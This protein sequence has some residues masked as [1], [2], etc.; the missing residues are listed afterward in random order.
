[1]SFSRLGGLDVDGDA[2]FND[3]VAV[4]VLAPTARLHLAA[5]TAVAGTASLKVGAGLLLAVT[6][7]GAVESD[8]AHLYW[9]DGG[10][11]RLQLDGGGGTLSDAYDAGAAAA[12]QTLVIL[13]ARGG[14]VVV[15]GTQAGFTGPVSLEVVNATGSVSFPRLGGLDVDGDAVFT[16]S[17]AV[18]VLAPTARLHLAAG[19][20]VAGTAS[21]KIDAGVLLAV[22]ESGAVE[23]DGT[24]LYWTDG[25]GTRLRL[26]GGGETLSQTYDA[27]AAAADQTLVILDARGGGVV[28]NATAVGL[29]AVTA[30]EVDVIGGSVNFYTAGG[31]DV[32]STISKVAAA[33]T[34]WNEVDLASSTLTLTGGPT[35]ATSVSMVRVGQ[36][37]INGA[38]TVTDAYNLRVDTSPAGTATLTR[39]WSLGAAGAVQFAAGL[40]LGAGLAAP[41]END[42][43]VGAG[44]T[45]VSEAN[46]GRLGYLA[47]ATQQFM[48]SL[49]TAAYVPL[50]VGPAVGGFTTGSVPFGVAGG[51]LSQDNPNFFWDN[52][53]K[54]L[55]VGVTPTA[56]LHVVQPL[57]NASVPTA[58][59]V[60]G[61]SHT[62]I[63]ASSECIGANFNFSA[64][65]Q[66]ATGALATQREIVFQ[67]PTYRFVGNSTITTA[68]TVAITG[69]PVAGTNATLTNPYALLVQSGQTRFNAGNLSSSNGDK[70]GLTITA[71][72]TTGT[73][74]GSNFA[75]LYLNYVLDQTS[76]AD[77][78]GIL[79]N[80]TQTS[81]LGSHSPIAVVIDTHPIFRMDGYGHLDIVETGQFGFTPVPIL[82]VEQLSGN[83]SIDAGVEWNMVRFDL[84]SNEQWSTGAL[85]TQRAFLINAPTYAFVGAS[86]LTTAA[87]MA[88]SGAPIKGANATLTNTSAL[89]LQGTY[90]LTTSS[91][92]INELA[93]V[94]T[95]NSSAG[96]AAFNAVNLGYTINQTGTSSG[97]VNGLRINAAETAVLGT[98]NLI[99]AQ[100]GA[101]D[102]FVVNRRGGVTITQGIVAGTT[103]FA[104]ALTVTGAAH[105]T[106][107]LSTEVVG[108]NL[109]LS[110]TKQWATGAIT[111][112]REVLVQ[113]PTYSFVGAST[114][115]TAATLAITDAPAAGA[116]ATLTTTLALWVQAGASRFVPTKN[117]VA[118]AGISWDGF[119]VAPA[120]LSIT[121]AT[122]PITSLNFV[123]I[124]QPTLSAASPVVTTDL[125][126]LRV[127]S[128]AFAGA[129]PASATRSWSLYVE[130]NARLGAGQTVAG[131]DVNAAGPYDV[132][133]TDYLLQVRRTTTSTISL[134]LPALTGG[135]VLNG[136]VVVVKDSGYN[137]TTNNITIARGNVADKIDN[138]SADVTMNM[139]GQ[140]VQLV[141]N[142]TTNNWEILSLYT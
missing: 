18:G 10:G 59:S 138:L 140:C 114:I 54:R 104:A 34:T 35:T 79:I 84:S 128:P 72:N 131:T 65:K 110:A 121:G 96:S 107:T 73:A 95:F 113:A 90:T 123:S 30:L 13:D 3:S 19:T 47:G 32:S 117:V 126:V 68:A 38:N 112:Q 40:V 85:T 99:Q 14:G 83:N 80:G 1:M 5:G 50:L 77:S 94:A 41:S 43:V 53:N 88:I 37:T 11:T 55:G 136:R 100:V 25:G 31:F 116:N 64:T 119:E 91:T 36:A 48:V 135:T 56:T 20:A 109:N 98:H 69:A 66:W 33:G 6:E 16:D 42:L 57:V 8:G 105:T 103:T 52:T 4:G 15:D 132:L 51:Q 44:A 45:V 86:T 111:T 127:A 92:T 67:A 12:D 9:T 23:S 124:G 81:V 71:T 17:V 133:A 139:N 130:G 60:V 75:P 101:V 39:S 142:T 76:N 82:E 134:N 93:T 137:C 125:Y 89:L 27:G 106:L 141:A 49:N 97:T 24:H 120:V 26:D 58:L 87:T 62:T 28:V 115:T 22:A 63:T 78:F 108:V 2:V 7:S 118:A 21:L 74:P 122:T 70:Y 29:A 129:G 102:R 46:T 61:G